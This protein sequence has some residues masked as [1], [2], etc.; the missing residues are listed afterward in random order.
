ME[1]SALA[2]MM[3]LPR[4]GHLDAVFHMFA[5]L[6]RMHNSII[7]FNPTEPEID[8][9]KFP[10]GDWSVTPY[11]EC[12]EE[13]PSNAPEPRGIAFT[14]RSFVDSDHAGDMITR[15]SRTGFLIFLN[16]APIYWFSKK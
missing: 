5:F 13:I 12:K 2:L 3:A 15:R 7:V 8:I 11:G 14:T 6:K 16:N 1:T 4:E 10:R 9:N